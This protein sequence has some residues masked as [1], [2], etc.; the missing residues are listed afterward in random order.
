MKKH[1]L[2]AIFF[3]AGL[4]A[5]S[6]KLPFQGKLIETGVP[7]DGTRTLEFS[8]ASQ[9]W[10]ETHADVP[11]TDG[12]YF[13]VL[14]SINP[15][16]D[17]LFYGVDEQS[18]DI[19][20]DGTALSPVILFKPLDSPFEGNDLSV[21]NTEGT[22]TG[23][24]TAQNDSVLTGELI[25]YGPSG[26]RNLTLSGDS[27][28]GNT[29]VIS[30]HGNESGAISQG[31]KA[32]QG[33]AGTDLP[34]I[35]LETRN[36][37]MAYLSAFNNIDAEN[38]DTTSVG[39]MFLRSTNGH[40]YSMQ[41]QGY[42]M[43]KDNKLTS[44]MMA[45]NWGGLGFSGHFDVRGPNSTNIALSSRHWEN[46]DLPWFYMSGS[47]DQ[48]VIQMSAESNEDESGNINILSKNGNS[49]YLSANGISAGNS[50]T[51]YYEFTTQDWG[52]QGQTGLLKIN[53]TTTQNFELTSQSWINPNF[54]WFKLSGENLGDAVQMFLDND[55]TEAANL[56]LFSLGRGSSSF[57]TDS[58]NMNGPATNNIS[59]GSRNWEGTPDLPFVNF[60]GEND[61]HGIELSITRDEESNQ[62]GW[63]NLMSENGKSLH[64]S[65]EGVGFEKVNINANEDGN[66]N[67]SGEIG[68]QGGNTLNIAMGGKHWED[69]TDLP[70]LHMFGT[71]DGVNDFHAIDMSVDG[72]NGEVA[73]L[74]L[75]AKNGMHNWLS[76][77]EV[78]LHGTNGN[79]T[80]SANTQNDGNGDYGLIHLYSDY[81][82][83]IRM[84]PTFIGLRDDANGYHHLV[85]IST[86]NN[87][88]NGWHGTINLNGS[89]TNNIQLGSKDWENT[90]LP[91]LSLNGERTNLMH[92]TGIGGANEFGYIHLMSEDGSTSN[93]SAY[94]IENNNGAGM[95]GYFGS[96]RTTFIDNGQEMTYNAWGISGSG[97]LSIS[98]G[99]NITGD[100]VVNGVTEHSSDRR[101]KKDIKS[102]APNTLEKIQFIEGVSYNWRQDE[103]PNKN[104]SSDKQI[105]VI[106]QELEAQFPELVKT[107][108]DGYKSVNYN[109]FTVVL[110]EAVKELNAKVEKSG[111]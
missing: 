102:L 96:D 61:F 50:S 28:T 103:F 48:N 29:G 17:S 105:G 92:L 52:G 27:E 59:F 26:E 86:N 107:N 8:I 39:Y 36:R 83:S 91:W 54:P 45:Q 11:I 20:V 34:F 66:G 31:F 88:G 42:W 76:A 100:V 95:T 41:P 101:F 44:Q 24:L 106:A 74:D 71:N 98:N 4:T 70:F 90:E 85:D 37:Y 65:P 30:I 109:G 84:E 9:S 7:V 99:V 77:T 51:Q 110:L 58:W 72:S 62:F 87:E 93:V 56:K 94:R 35:S 1:V 38:N 60:F 89:N 19:S 18:L 25:L 75:R 67:K 111:E 33:E 46:P 22:V 73:Y 49:T 3:V 97:T 79:Q 57:T 5:F 40:Q 68:I 80:F 23:S 2:L 12:L 10:S 47:E 6:Q 63:I 15:L 32:W 81:Q 13:V 69:N 108:K 21:K 64:L 14:G 16:P 104:F 78:V 43:Y 55:G 53:G 82:K